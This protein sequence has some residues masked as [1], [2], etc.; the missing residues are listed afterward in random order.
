MSFRLTNPFKKYHNNPAK[1]L[2]YFCIDKEITENKAIC[3]EWS[4]FDIK[5]IFDVHFWWRDKTDDHAG[6][7]ILFQIFGF[8]PA[9]EFYDKRHAE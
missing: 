5:E 7:S 8:G 9:I 1:Y 3:F 2:S 4:K 6:V